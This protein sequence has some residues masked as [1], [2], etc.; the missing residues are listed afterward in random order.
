M[1]AWSRLQKDVAMRYAVDLVV[2]GVFFWIGVSLFDS[3]GLG[4]A[5]GLIFAGAIAGRPRGGAG[6][7]KRG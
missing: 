5:C 3:A 1:I 4:A 7:A 6:A 2:F